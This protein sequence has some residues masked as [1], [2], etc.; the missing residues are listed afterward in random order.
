MLTVCIIGGTKVN[1]KLGEV[2]R[3]WRKMADLTVRQAAKEIGI[4][5][6]TLSRIEKGYAMDG[7]TLARI[8]GWL[9]SEVLK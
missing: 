2:L 6:P 5:F 4:S 3:Q 7:R 9:T 1:M 8:Q